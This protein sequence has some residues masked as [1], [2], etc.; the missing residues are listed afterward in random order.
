MAETYKISTHASL[1]DSTADWSVTLDNAEHMLQYQ[2]YANTLI[3]ACVAKLGEYA[4]ELAN[5]DRAIQDGA[6]ALLH[7]IESC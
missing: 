1:A 7:T 5:N 4:L 3:A 2:I 6:K